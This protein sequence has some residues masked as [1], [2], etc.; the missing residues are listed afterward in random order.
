MP[1]YSVIIPVYN[2]PDE[3]H[4]LLESLTLQSHRDFEVLIIDDGS[5]IPSEAVVRSF[6]AR[7]DIYYHHRE[8]VGQGFSRNY[9]AHVSRGKWLVFFD[10]DCVIPYKY[11]EE[12]DILINADALVHAFC[13]PDAAHPSFSALQRAIS[14]SMTSLLT[15]G[16]I[17]GKK[18]STEKN[19]HLRSYNMVVLKTIFEEIGGFAKTNMGEDMEFSARFQKREYISIISQKLT[20]YHKRRNTLKSFYK[21]VH[22]FGRTRV[23]L[24]REYAIPVKITHLFPA[25][26][27]CGLFILP[28]IPFMFPPTIMWIVYAGF[29]IYCLAIILDSI[30]QNKDLKVALLSLITS[31]IQLTGYGLGFISELFRS[32]K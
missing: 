4:E 17:R 28:F 7:L 11:F 26:F 27:V 16:G 10:S 31:F 15:T 20:V 9:G 3:L 13:G 1:K 8:N 18:I 32:E 14:Y 19:R 30:I 29:L 22:S 5:T 21:Q 23:Q 12:L 2:R 25:T 24:K 6:E